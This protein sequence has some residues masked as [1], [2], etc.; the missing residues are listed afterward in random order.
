MEIKPLLI[1]GDGT[2]ATETLDIAETAGGFKPLGF[3]NS[4]ERPASGAVHA[5]LPVF[6]IDE[7]PFR[8]AECYLVAGIVSTTRRNFIETMLARDYKFTSVIHPS[9]T[10]SRRSSIAAGCVINA[11]VVISANTRVQAH[12]ILNRGCLIGHDNLI[13]PFCTIGPGANLAGGLEI[14]EGAYIA[15]GAVIRDHVTI[16]AG[17]VVGGGA[18]VVKSVPPNVLVAGLPAQIMK[19]DVKGL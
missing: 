6:W 19:T 10:I 9:A 11:G 14:G 8:P 7:I 12:V 17:S 4:L 2:F 18:V 13:Q 16:G 5:G 1:L 15:V 3:V